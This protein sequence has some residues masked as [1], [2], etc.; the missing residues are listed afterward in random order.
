MFN[1][2]R[3]AA[4]PES[5]LKRTKY[6]GDDVYQALEDIFFN[7]CYL[8][9]T[10][11]PQD[12]NVEHFDAHMGN[13]DKKFDWNN[14]Y[15]VCSR[16]NNIKGAKYNNLLDCCDA[17]TD[18]FRAIKHMPP[19]TPYAKNVSIEA[20]DSKVET[21]QTHE[22]LDKIFN[23]EHTI[24]KKVSGSF[25]RR[26]V[27]ERYNLL[28]DQINMYYSPIATNAEKGQALERI[29]VLIERSAPYSAFIRWCVL[30]DSE[31]GPMFS[32]LIE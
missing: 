32:H 14:L 4:V 9:E 27:F 17:S 18:V 15:F 23:S 2:I 11:E 21:T 29:Q 28:L 19:V 25:L 6:D 20:M 5:L 24:N 30:E 26:K 7:K 8:C 3:P 10:K 12:I 16:C 31:L 1:V 13:L 22:L